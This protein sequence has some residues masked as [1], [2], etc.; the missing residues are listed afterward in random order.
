MT[1]CSK[2]CQKEDWLNGHNVTC[3]KQFAVESAGQ[4]QGRLIPRTM[5]ESERDATKLEQLEVNIMMIQLNLFLDERETILKQAGDL[6]IPLCDCVVEFDLRGCPPFVKTLSYNELFGTPGARRAFEDGR[7][8][9]YITCIY[10]SNFYNG[11]VD[12]H[13]NI[14][15]L[16]MQKIFPLEWLF[17]KK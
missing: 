5:P 13:G 12:E 3:N 9:E 8:K 6:G 14:P 2:V 10:N 17:S 4:F 16:K 1:Y 15:Y 7:S 11:E